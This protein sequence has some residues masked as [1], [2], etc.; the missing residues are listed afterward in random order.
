M[1]NFKLYMNSNYAGCRLV[2]TGYD[3]HRKRDVRMYQ[4]PGEPEALGVS[5]GTDR[6][7]APLSSPFL[8][9]V[10]DAIRQ[11][12][13]GEAV[14]FPVVLQERPGGAV[15]QRRERRRIQHDEPQA[16]PRQRR[17]IIR[18]EPTPARQRVRIQ[19]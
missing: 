12:V 4:I 5:D 15:G 6:W 10:L 13:S 7:I 18:E 9:P 14:T 11:S 16:A 8:K 2:A 1:A 19:H 17:V 3:P